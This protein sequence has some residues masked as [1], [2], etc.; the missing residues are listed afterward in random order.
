MTPALAP[1]RLAGEI[2][3]R[4]KPHSFPSW[5]SF[6]DDEIAAATE[7][8]RSGRVNYWTG[9]HGRKFEQEF[10]AVCGCKHAVAVANGTVAL[11]LALR[12]LAIGAGDDVVVP[13][14]TFIASAS[15]V[16]MCG[17]H[18]VFADVDRDSQNIT[19]ATIEPALT[20]ATRAIVAVHFAGWPCEM[21]S[22]VELAR[23]KNLLVIED[24]AQ[25]QGARY[26]GKPVGSF[27]DAAAF[28]FC[29][30]KIMTTAGE[31]GMLV[32]NDSAV[33]ERA[34]AF[35]DHGKDPRAAH[36]NGNGG[37][38]R[39]VHRSVGTNWRMTEV[40]AAIGRR[41]LLKVPA[42]LEQRRHNANIL[43]A[44]L[45]QLPALRVPVLPV[46]ID[47]AFYRFS[48]FLRP[49]T[50]KPDW[51]RDRVLEAILSRGV[52]CSSG[53]SGELYLEQA[54]ASSRP[55]QRLAV[56]RELADTSLAFLVH[57]TLGKDDMDAMSGII[58]DVVRAAALV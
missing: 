26:C 57:P 34:R 3:S 22:I 48:A 20:P 53:G 7:V 29:Q 6:S 17:A 42:W 50:L 8:L 5:P 51:N 43:H 55:P 2:A 25:A 33:F 24:C 4:S 15:C 39:F 31:G 18:P 45:S 32:T 41:Q 44:H 14:R 11:E 28:S 21:N 9:E 35:K 47:H 36:V 38:P 1:A 54:F 16:A 19:A 12:S 58:A 46:H 40:Q 13:S 52:P 37:G 27:G 10:A 49:K 23:G 56:A 30:D